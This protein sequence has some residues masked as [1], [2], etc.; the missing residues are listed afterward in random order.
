MHHFLFCLMM[1]AHSASET[2]FLTRDDGKRKIHSGVKRPRTSLSQFRRNRIRRGGAMNWGPHQSSLVYYSLKFAK[3]SISGR[4]QSLYRHTL[5]AILLN[6]VLHA[7][8]LLYIYVLS[9][10]MLSWSSP[11]PTTSLY[12]NVKVG[13][14]SNAKKLHF[15]ESRFGFTICRN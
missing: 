9:R 12:M 6:S 2:L 5:S 15:D 11:I 8:L 1:A 13:L 7:Y 4:H 14:R 10:L 3:T